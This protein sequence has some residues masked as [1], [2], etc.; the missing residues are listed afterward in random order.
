MKFDRYI[1]RG[2]LPTLLVGWGW[3]LAAC[4]DHTVHIED[5][6]EQQTGSMLRIGSLTRSDSST[7]PFEGGAEVKLFLVP[8]GGDA[9]APGI[10]KKDDSSGDIIWN[11]NPL[12]VKPGADYTIFGFLPAAVTTGTSGV[13]VDDEEGQATMTINDLPAVTTLDLCV[14]IGVKEG[15]LT[16]DQPVVTPGKFAYHASENTA[17]DY[18]VS[19]LADHLYAGVTFNFYIDPTYKALRTIKLKEVVMKTTSKTLNV[20][21]PFAMN[22]VDPM[23]TPPTYTPTATA[24]VDVPLYQSVGEE[25]TVKS[26]NP[27]ANTPITFTAYFSPAIVDPD[28]PDIQSGLSIVSTYDVYDK[29]GHLVSENRQAENSLAAPLLGL[30][31]AQKRIITLTVNPTYLYILSNWD[32]DNPEFV[33]E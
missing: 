23:G 14:I 18:Y 28:D 2:L 27:S 1:H 24:Q 8:Q 25:L 10:V 17:D 32:I 5:Q 21:I 12:M 33:I 22:N 13:M 30:Q 19:L 20:S 26:T 4:S 7:D 9:K 3:L 29:D 11:G 16:A 6:P 15:Q 31:R